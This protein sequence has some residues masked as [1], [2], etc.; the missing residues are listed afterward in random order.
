MR[1]LLPILACL[2][3]G[4]AP[5]AQDAQPPA[6]EGVLCAWAIYIAI[7]EVGRRCFPGQNPALQARLT[8]ANERI[9]RYVRDNSAITDEAVASFRRQMGEADMPDAAFCKGDFVDMYGRS[10]GKEL[11]R[12]DD[13]DK[14]LA[15][16]GEPKWGTCV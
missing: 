6:G 11:A 9:E 14:L 8:A 13:L 7:E 4:A 1:A 3:L 2:T 15:R 16:P 10:K 5:I 12:T